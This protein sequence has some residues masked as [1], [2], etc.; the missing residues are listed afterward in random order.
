MIYD[1]TSFN[2]TKKSLADLL[3]LEEWRIEEFIFLE[4][5]DLIELLEEFDITDEK[6][7]EKEIELVSI[8]N[9]TTNDG[10]LSLKE[11]GII[12]LQAVCRS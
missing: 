7:L 10:C 5:T 6:I 11:K 2:S 12:N 1:I 4:S 8:R 9:T 3:N